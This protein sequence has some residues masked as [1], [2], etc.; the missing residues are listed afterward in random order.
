MKHIVIIGATSLIAEHCARLWVSEPVRLTLVGRDGER[1]ARLAGDLQV[2]SPQSEV[3]TLTADF[4]KSSAIDTLVAD[5]DKGGPVDIALIAHGMLPEQ[6]ACQND[7]ALVDAAI[8]VNGVSP[9]L[10]AEAF[11]QYMAVRNKGTIAV[12]GSVAGDRGRR[13]NYVYGASKAL[14]EGYLQGMQHRFAGTGVR[15]V[16]I[17]PGPTRTPMTAGMAD[18][19]MR[20][21]DPAQVAADIVRGVAAGQRTVYTPGRWRW[22]M[23]VIRHLPAFIFNKL[24]I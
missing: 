5:L 13:S 2:R 9:C 20:F 1:L 3:H 10:F 21:A 11:A 19:G 16:L 23:L 12:I 18:A 17:K 15:A 4:L 24:N 14:V 22:I 8:A 7:L 6:A